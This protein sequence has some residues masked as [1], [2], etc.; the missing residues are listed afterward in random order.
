MTN[1]STSHLFMIE[2]ESF[3]SNEQTASSNH[4]Q[5]KE[6][7]EVADKI[8]EQALKEFHGLKNSIEKRGIKVTCLKGSSDC[9]DHI[10][11][12]WFI[13]FENKTFQLFSMKA[14]NRRLEK[15]K[16]MIDFLSQNYR[17]S[18]DL[19]EFENAKNVPT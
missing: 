11:P 18:G 19:T 4:Y 1:Q 16:E 7:D 9:P 14:E 3:Y 10:F 8:A 6:V 13:T 5:A 2:P 12:N 15:T 17:L